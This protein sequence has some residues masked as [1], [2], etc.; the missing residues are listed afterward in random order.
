M[1]QV[2]LF[3]IISVKAGMNYGLV[4]SPDKPSADHRFFYYIFARFS[5]PHCHHRPPPQTR[6]F[7]FPITSPWALCHCC[8]RC[9]RRRHGMRRVNKVQLISS[10]N[11]FFVIIKRIFKP[12][13]H[14]W[15]FIKFNTVFNTLFT[16]KNTLQ[17]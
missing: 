17:V 14:I 2:S 6:H 15:G 7:F 1:E 9:W 5:Y 16:T 13:C 3:K 8:R 4:I 11:L 10:I 12:I